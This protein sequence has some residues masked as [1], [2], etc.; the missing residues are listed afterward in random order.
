MSK[1]NTLRLFVFA[2]L[3]FGLTLGAS[4]HPI[5][6]TD[7]FLRVG[8]EQADAQITIFLEDLYFFQNLAPDERD[9]LSL[10]A[11][12]EG[13]ERHRQFLLERFV[14]RDAKGE[15]LP[16]QAIKLEMPE[17]PSEGVPLAEL[18]SHK[19]AY[20]FRYPFDSPPEFLTVSQKLVDQL[21]AVP[22]EMRLVAQQGDS[23]AAFTAVLNSEEPQTMRF[24]WSGPQLTQKPT[25]EELEK[26]FAEQHKK[27]L[28]ITSYNTV[29]A[30]LYA[31]P[32]DVR[33]EVL[34]PLVKLDEIQPQ[35]R[36]DPDFLSPAE[37]DQAREALTTYFESIAELKLEGATESLRV[38]RIDFFGVNARDLAAD[39]PRERISMASGR[40]GVILHAPRSQPVESLELTWN[41]FSESLY[42]AQLFYF[43]DEG[44]ER[45]T[46]AK[47]GA[48]RRFVWRRTKA[49]PKLAAA[50][51]PPRVQLT[52]R[53]IW[54]APWMAIPPILLGAPLLAFARTRWTAA[55]L[56]L[57]GLLL[58]PLQGAIPSPLVAP[59][60]VDDDRAQS[61][62]VDLLGDTY[63][64]FRMRDEEATYD[65]LSH[66][67]DGKLLDRLYTQIRES[68]VMQ[69]Q[70]GAVATVRKIEPLDGEI[71]PPPSS[72][73]ERS[74]RYRLSWL[75]EGEV[76]HWG[77]VHA[78]ANR[79]DAVFTVEPQFG[80][81]MLTDLEL[82]S[83]ERLPIIT[84]VRGVD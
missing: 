2:L 7:C 51:E 43:S 49:A 39:A 37:Q 9:F 60:Q 76:E 64:A 14:L 59:P 58:L 12:Q 34:F 26:W 22:A 23:G 65:W 42:T 10:D 18:M 5:S 73:D 1:Q 80:R 83:E 82:I 35:P 46:L 47:L 84:R 48:A 13:A 52:P 50:P 24:D 67:A 61:V 36:E 3:A 17:L 38:A 78:R 71:Q 75:V 55:A 63:A 28:G 11:I 27:T 44:F 8:R 81:W 6:V 29:Y 33:L 68:I 62:V 72:D 41:G 70:G 57:L 69:Q 15:R 31:E 74:F 20:H 53:P 56:L 30:F 32:F 40:V 21:V 25:A 45:K 4:A 16:G 79:Y 66:C 19:I 77:H 54:R